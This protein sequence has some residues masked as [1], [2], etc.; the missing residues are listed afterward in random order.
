MGPRGLGQRVIWSS[1][2]L[3]LELL[4]LGGKFEL[5]LFADGCLG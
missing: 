5:V 4:V 2:V 3:Q 1:L